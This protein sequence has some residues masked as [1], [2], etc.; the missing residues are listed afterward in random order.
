ML[1]FFKDL[2][3]FR[4][5]V[6]EGRDGEG[7]LGSVIKEITDEFEGVGVHLE[8]TLVVGHVH[9]SF[10]LEFEEFGPML[11]GDLAEGRADLFLFI[12]SDFDD[13]PLRPLGV[14]GLGEDEL[15]RVVAE[16]FVLSVLVDA[17][18]ASVLGT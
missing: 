4:D 9:E 8:F 6:G 13:E 16:L 5:V 10:D 1:I 7:R 15:G 11:A 17:V 14:G 3:A 12:E 2:P 18:E